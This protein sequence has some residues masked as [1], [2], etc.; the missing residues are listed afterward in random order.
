MGWYAVLLS[1]LIRSIEHDFHQSDAGFSVLFLAEAITYGVFAMLAGPIGERWGRH[2]VVMTGAAVAGIGLFCL[3]VA[4]SW[5]LAIV[6]CTVISMGG[7]MIDVTTNALFMDLHSD[8]KAGALN[9]LHGSFS[10]GALIAPVA[11][12]T[13]ITLGVPW[14]LVVIVCGLGFL[15]LAAL[16]LA[17][18]SP[19]VSTDRH[20][21][22]RHQRR[23]YGDMPRSPAL[24]GLVVGIGLYCAAEIGISSWIVR[25]LAG[26]SL[27]VATA[28]LSGFW[29][30][31]TVGRVLS[32]WVAERLNYF[33]FTVVCLALAS[34]ALIGAATLP[35]LPVVAALFALT[36]FF[37]GPIYPTM[38]ALGGTVFPD[39]LSLVSSWLTG[40]A[41]VGATIYAPAMG[42]LEAHIGLEGGMIGAALLGV[43]AIAGVLL[44][45]TIA[46]QHL[47]A[48]VASQQLV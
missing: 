25:F 27:P 40:A 36:G 17:T 21:R 42:V 4:P 9:L 24:W 13:V 1:S 15:G 48:A 2:R 22:Q 16:L 32:R 23:G 28:V 6:A 10:G 44:A 29:G 35:W 5:I 11:M 31:L 45:R 12:G 3:G 33:V 8:A 14:R 18:H 37:Y 26:Q 19:H 43:P 47:P 34:L 20:E 39:R 41:V 7:G 30:G 38:M 46:A